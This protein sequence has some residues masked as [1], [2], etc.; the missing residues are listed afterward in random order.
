MSEIDLL[1]S[2]VL[3]LPWWGHVIV[4][5]VLTHITIVAATVFLHRHQAHRALDLHPAVSHF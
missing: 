3:E 4:D 5:L 1:F 2:G